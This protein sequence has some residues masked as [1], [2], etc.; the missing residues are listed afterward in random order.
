M[1][2]VVRTYTGANAK[3]LADLLA[4]HRSEVEGLLR[5]VS[6]LVS[7]TATRTA[8]GATTIT[9]CQSK[10]GAEESMKVARDWI[11]KRGSSLGVGAPAIG[12]GEVIM[13]LK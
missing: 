7:Y 10:A 1:Y 11:A 6:G 13:H 9:V 5:G 4:E 12:E 3:K 8:D 2:A